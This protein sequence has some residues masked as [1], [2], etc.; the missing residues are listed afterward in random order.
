MRAMV[1]GSRKFL[2]RSVIAEALGAINDLPGQHTL[3]HG[4]APGADRIAAGIAHHLGWT[5]E[6]HPAPWQEPCV[7]SCNH[8]RGRGVHPNGTFCPSAG[9]FRN[10]RMVALG[11]DICL[12]FYAVGEKNAGTTDCVK[13]AG[14]AHIPIHRFT[15]KPAAVQGVLL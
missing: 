7:P 12:A 8:R 5:I 4:D 3:V 14:A 6:S 13:R 10:G 11:A 1:T 9:V 15:D 2:N